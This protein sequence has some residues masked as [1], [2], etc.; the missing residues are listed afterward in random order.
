MIWL[1]GQSKTAKRP[2]NPHFS[3]ASHTSRDSHASH[4]S[5]PPIFL[6]SPLANLA[7]PHEIATYPFHALIAEDET[8]LHQSENASAP[9]LSDQPGM[10]VRSAQCLRPHRAGRHP[11]LR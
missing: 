4:D 1:G 5:H 10:A 9:P 2:P 6:I 3:L 7:K 8:D 11:R